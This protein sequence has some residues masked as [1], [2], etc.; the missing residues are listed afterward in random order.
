M[1]W[2][3]DYAEAGLEGGGEGKD[4]GWKLGGWKEDQQPRRE[5]GVEEQDWQASVSVA[6]APPTLHRFGDSG[7]PRGWG[8]P[9]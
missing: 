4:R 9:A 5:D 1:G 3:S 6:V 2:G 7:T 8:S